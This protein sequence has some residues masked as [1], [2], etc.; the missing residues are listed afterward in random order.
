MKLARWLLLAAC[1]LPLT[2]RAQPA[3][4]A[5][6]GFNP[7]PPAFGRQAMV[8]TGDQRASEAALAM[9]RQ[10]GSATDAAIAALM[11]LNLVE[12][13]SSGIGG[14][15]FML[16]YD[17][18]E[19]AV[20][21]YDGRETAPAAADPQWFLKADGKP[22]G[23]REAVRDGRSIG[24]PGLLRMLELAHD[25]HGR[26][27]W[28]KLFEPAIVLARDG[29][30][31]SQ[32]LHRL[33]AIE[34]REG[35][36]IQPRA[37]AYFLSPQG[38]PWPVGTLLRNPAY[39]QTLESVAERGAD[40]FYRGALAAKIV[41]AVSSHPV[42][43]G[44][45]AAADLSAYRA[46]EREPVC[47]DY[48]R[49]RVCGMGP[50]S[51]GATTV[52]SILG[53][54]QRFGLSQLDPGSAMVTHLFSEAGR[55]AYADRGA[56]LADADFEPV[57]LKRLL[58]PAYLRKRAGTIRFEHGGRRAEPGFSSAVSG[59]SVSQP[60]TTHLSIVDSRGNAVSLTASIEDAF[61]NRSMVAGFLLNNQ[62][63]DF[64]FQPERDG[65]PVANR[66]VAG[67]RPRSSM[68]PTL[69]FAP[70][71][72]LRAVL[73]SPGGS[74]I[75]NFVAQSVSGL[76]DWG[77]SAAEIV[78]RPRV[79]SRNGPTE[80]EAGSAAEQQAGVLRALGHEL[81]VRPMTSGLNL[82]VRE[83]DRWVG[84]ADPRREGFALGY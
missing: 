69:V 62:L 64:S 49:H 52:L 14:G 78:A 36:F 54:L 72:Q 10:G 18:V 68:A 21:S 70:D 6:S 80:I 34:A 2:V 67:K 46:I 9:L 35:R 65:V 23:F 42:R 12:P 22:L 26:L 66:V 61:G 33:L 38:R 8:V 24:V 31:V 84:A 82:I 43:S 48:R 20:R 81:R 5:A 76:L 79:G 16:H 3:P 30:R 44:G 27:P 71:G 25:R 77:L 37:R 83:G 7:T 55:L 1:M 75:I 51:S 45:L 17:G 59:S 56:H 28:A 41:E 4:E 13:Q 11:V 57:P 50:P 29:F 63:T 15:A 40:A 47:A 53:M 19:R 60:S 58:D 32:R 73:G 74:Q 39:A